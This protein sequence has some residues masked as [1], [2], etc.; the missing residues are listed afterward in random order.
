ML[1]YATIYLQ[2]KHL[3]LLSPT[4]K[5]YVENLYIEKKINFLFNA[6]PQ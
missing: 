1:S 4:S 5:N 2:L 6:K 3:F